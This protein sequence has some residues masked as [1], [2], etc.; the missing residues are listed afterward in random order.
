[1]SSSTK[2][3]V[4]PESNGNSGKVEQTHKKIEAIKGHPVLIPPPSTNLGQ[5]VP[6]A[7]PQANLKPS[8]N[9]NTSQTT[10]K[11]SKPTKK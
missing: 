8:G 6:S 1:M 11:T 3:N 4:T 10:P 2:A 7:P 5:N 9:T